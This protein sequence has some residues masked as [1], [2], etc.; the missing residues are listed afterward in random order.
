MYDVVA[1]VHDSIE[2]GSPLEEQRREHPST[3]PP[4]LPFNC[5]AAEVAN[6]V[7]M[8]TTRL[9]RVLRGHG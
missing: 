9:A 7:S 8:T 5:A 3:P 6:S 1:R 4:R 2:M